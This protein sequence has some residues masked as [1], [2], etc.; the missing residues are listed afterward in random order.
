MGDCVLCLAGVVITVLFE[1]IF[2]QLL[3]C[4][5]LVY[6]FYSQQNLVSFPSFDSMLPTPKEA[7]D[8]INDDLDLTIA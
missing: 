7:L 2:Y 1:P 3:L 6:R 8:L 4:S 5:E